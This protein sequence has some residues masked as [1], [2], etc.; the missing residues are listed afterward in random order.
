MTEVT[1][2]LTKT[3]TLPMSLTCHTTGYMDK[4]IHP[5]RH[6]IGAR[7]CAAGAPYEL[8]AYNPEGNKDNPFELKTETWLTSNETVLTTHW[9]SYDFMVKY[10]NVPF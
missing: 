5:D 3:I 2:Q 10:F 9:M 1:V 6:E 8:V 4:Y 7:F